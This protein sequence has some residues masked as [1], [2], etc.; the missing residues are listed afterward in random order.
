MLFFRRKETS[1]VYQ[2]KE[3][4][5]MRTPPSAAETVVGTFLRSVEKFIV[6]WY[7]LFGK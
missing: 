2:I 1:F 7:N 4:F 3:V 6:L 5:L